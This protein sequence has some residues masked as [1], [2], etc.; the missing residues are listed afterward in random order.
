MSI[1]KVA[2]IESDSEIYFRLRWW[3]HSFG[4]VQ[5]YSHT[6]FR[7]GISIHGWVI[8]TV[9][10]ITDGRQPCW[11]STSG[12]I[13]VFFIIISMLVCIGVPNFIQITHGRWREAASFDFVWIIVGPSLIVKSGVVRFDIL[14]DIA[15]L[16][17][18]RG[19]FTW[20]F[21]LCIMKSKFTS[22]VETIHIFGFMLSICIF[23]IKL[24][25]E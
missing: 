11:N 19:I 17:F 1:F 10:Q 13:W 12:S 25:R 6:K 23:G 2:A 8:T 4:N 16:T 14:V 5:I 20:L 9:L 21:P 22:K 15:I 3:R 24:L 7:W 18:W